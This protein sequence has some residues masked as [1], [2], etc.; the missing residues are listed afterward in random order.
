MAFIGVSTLIQLLAVY[1]QNKKRGMKVVAYEAMLVLTMVKPAIDAR[2]VANG[3]VKI[4][5]T[6][7][8]P[9]L[10]LIYTKVIEMFS[11]S[12]PSSILQTFAM[13][14]GDGV[15]K[16]AVSSIVVSAMA[17]AFASATIS[18]DLDTDPE[19]RK[20]VPEFYGYMP[21]KNRLLV[22]FLM[23]IMTSAHVLMKILACSLMLRLNQVWFA[24]YLAGDMCIYFLFKIVRGD[25]RYFLNLSEILSWIGSFLIRSIVK[26]I[27][28]FTLMIHFRHPF[29]LS[30][31]YWSA[32]I[33]MNQIFCFVAVYL[34]GEFSKDANEKNDRNIVCG[35]RWIVYP[36][37]D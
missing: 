24:L 8:D 5:E 26:I 28:D 33:V 14:G 22:F 3:N 7:F 16:T 27:T 19:R 10:E 13:L 11:E 20:L 18:N 17:I 31:I 21:N 6:L 9:V 29:E 1:G 2:R 4:D 12:I 23:M 25:F 34:D 32:N 37:N 30:G 35:S 15:S 36:V